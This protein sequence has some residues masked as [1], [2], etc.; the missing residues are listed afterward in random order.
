MKK[1]DYLI[2]GGGMAADAAASTLRR[3]DAEAAI[4]LITE[5]NHPPYKRPPLSKGLWGKN[6]LDNIWL[7]TAE[8]EIDIHTETRIE[9][10]DLTQKNVSDREGNL[11]S[12]DKLLLAT[13]GSPKKLPFG[14]NHILYYRTLEDYQFLRGQAEDK[15][16][17][18]VLGGGFIGSEIAAALNQNGKNVTMLIPETGIGAAIFPKDLSDFITQYYREKGVKVF[19][20]QFARGL[21]TVKSGYRVKTDQEEFHTEQVIAGVGI[22]PNVTLAAEAGLDVENGIFVDAFLRAKHPDVYAAGDAA[23]IQHAI[24]KKNFRFEHEDNAVKMG[25]IAAKNMTGES[26]RYDDYLPFFYSDLFDLGYEAVGL[27]DPNMR[28]VADWQEKYRQGVLY[29]HCDG[30]VMGILLWNVWGALDTSRELIRE[31]QSKPIK[32]SEL[33]GL[34]K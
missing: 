24:F 2:I 34:I 15:E 17:F 6:S 33:I 8:K 25:S 3:K 28:I 10:L 29:Y 19:P 11:I 27:L 21:Q 12:F 20:G 32:P 9:K 26:I 30:H 13:G 5:E 14:E 7:K 22:K 18:L 31:T 23:S 4:G 1:Y 16:Q